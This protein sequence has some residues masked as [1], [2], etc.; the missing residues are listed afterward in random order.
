[1]KRRRSQIHAYSVRKEDMQRAC[2]R[3]EDN[4]DNVR[5]RQ[6]IHSGDP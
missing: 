2:V 6:M 1:M 3:E 5:W 4:R